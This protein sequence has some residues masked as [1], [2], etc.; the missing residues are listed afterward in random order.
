MKTILVFEDS[1]RANFGGGQNITLRVCDILKE[2]FNLRF[3]DFISTSRYAQ[4]VKDLYGE[5]NLISIGHGSISG[6]TGSWTWLKMIIV[7]CLYLLEDSKKILKGL[8]PSDCICYSTGKRS[9]LIAAYL[10]KRY[11]IPY[12]HHAHL[13]ENPNGI[14]FN[15]AKRLFASAESVLCV[16][17][18]VMSS[19]NTKNSQLVYNPSLN[20][21]GFKGEKSDNKF[22]VAFVGSLIP[23]KGVEYFVDAAK[24]C[25]KDIEFRI[26]GE[27]FLRETLEKRAEGRVHFM[28]FESNIIDRYYEDIDI[29]V[30]PTVLQEALPLVVVD[31][32]SV[33]LPVIVTSPGGQSEIVRDGI[34]GFHVPMKDANAIA[35]KVEDLAKNICLYRSMAKASYTSSWLFSYDIFNERV[36]TSFIS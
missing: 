24:L 25:H 17:R 15:I 6:H 28:G 12:I 32:K 21:R 11:D 13:V 22:V 23:I 14:Y 33:G 10:K 5:E 4:M 19:I 27:G 36:I 1:T 35:E 7:S 30:I 29:L 9:L 8:D 2:R 16:S 31:A 26:Y 3:V 18:T 34:D 20:A